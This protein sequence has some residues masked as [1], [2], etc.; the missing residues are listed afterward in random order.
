MVLFPNCKINLGLNIVR[1]RSDGFHDIETVFYPIALRDALEVIQTN[2]IEENV[3]YSIPIATGIDFQFSTSG[4]TVAGDPEDNLCI[5]AYQ[6]LKKNFT[7]LPAVK[8]HLHKTIPSGSGLG[9]GSADGA[10]V[11]RLLNQKFHL[12]LSTEQ[13][14]GY[15]LQLGSDCPFFIINRPCFATGR[16]EILEPI[17]P[18]LS[19]YKIVIINPGIHISTTE[20]FS[21]LTPA[22]PSKSIKKIIQQPI[23]TWKEELKNDFE[24]PVFRKYPELKTIKEK[25][26]EA[27]AIYTSMTGSG[28]TIYGIFEKNKKMKL[29]FT[30]NYFIKELT[31]QLQ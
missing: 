31:G 2:G 16:G 5:K 9:A 20:A 18:D 28:S 30:S 29:S 8:M 17:Q 4:E 6:L 3:Q 21:L 13:L 22:I 24:E 1:K 25:L 11:L 7:Q 27:G 10:V 26:Y 15:A 19:D 12:G 14:L 23:E